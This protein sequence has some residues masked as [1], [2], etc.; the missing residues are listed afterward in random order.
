MMGYP[1]LETAVD[2]AAYID[3]LSLKETTA[4]LL[5]VP[6]EVLIVLTEA[7]ELPDG[8]F[9]L[10][11]DR[12]KGSATEVHFMPIED[13]SAPDDAFIVQ[14]SALQPHMR[15]RLASGASCAFCCQYG[16]GRSGMMAALLLME[17]GL[18]ADEAIALVRSHFAEAVESEIQH[19]WLQ[20]RQPGSAQK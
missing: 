16:A 12:M 9:G 13:F 6:V 18:S 8:A 4:A 20:S 7:E 10:M 1:G 14:W 11:L 15:K 19:S 2:G 17:R 5:A 3:P